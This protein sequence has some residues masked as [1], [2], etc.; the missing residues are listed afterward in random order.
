MKRSALSALTA[1][2]LF[3]AGS[4]ADPQWNASAVTGVSGVGAGSEYWQDTRWYNG[5]RADVLFGRTR[6]SDL[7]L[8][9]FASVTTA[10][11]DDLR[12][13]AGGTLLLPIT[14]YFPL[15]LSLG[16]YA[17]RDAEWQP[18]ISGW[19]F[20]GS[21]SYNFHSSYVMAGGILLGLERDLR[22]PST[23]AIVIGAQIDGLLLAL[24]FLFTYEWLRG[25]RDED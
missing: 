6:Y 21:R 14:S 9:P 13:G 25:G 23:N 12:L 17:R 8:G 10:G 2:L 20:L 22:D 1:T 18:G 15:G 16:G 4:R 7:S 11:F 19:L 24:P 5:A 3:A